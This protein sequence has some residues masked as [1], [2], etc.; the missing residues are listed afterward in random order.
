[1][2]TQ[3]PHCDA[4]FQLSTAQ[5]KAANGDVRCGQCLAV[6]S[7]LD[8]LSDDLP[9]ASG[10]SPTSVADSGHATLW[11]ED[12]L[13]TAP[14]EDDATE[15]TS[16]SRAGTITD[17]EE[18]VAASPAE[19]SSP[20]TDLDTAPDTSSSITSDSP[21]ADIFNEI[22]AEAS[23]HTLPSE[24]ID[25]FEAFL[26]ADSPT[27][28]DDVAASADAD[29]GINSNI[30]ADPHSETTAA[31][32]DFDTDHTDHIDRSTPPTA[33]AFS[34]TALDGY[35]FD[36][37]GI[38]DRETIDT[39]FVAEIVL[40][41]TDELAE[42]DAFLSATETIADDRSAEP[43]TAFEHD[44]AADL[45]SDSQPI[46]IE[47]ADLAPI[48]AAANHD[49]PVP[50]TAAPLDTDAI[51]ATID[52]PI[53]QAATE[54]AEVDDFAEL[55][56][57]A[58]E[59]EAV[60]GPRPSAAAHTDATPQPDSQQTLNVPQLILDDLHAARAEQL[61]P[62]PIPW[63]IGS[64]LL[65][66]TLVLQVAYFSRDE[67]ARDASLRP[68]LIQLCQLAGC[69]LNQ[70]YDI[71]QIEIIGREVRSH[72][73]ARK[74]LIASTSLINHASFVQPYP[75]VTVVFSDINGK[76]MALRRFTPREYLSNN[77]DLAAGMPPDMPVRIELELVDPG[78]AA[79][80]YEFSAEL[81]PR[82]TRPLT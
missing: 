71:A 60:V 61:R 74:A 29:T 41:A 14:I 20:D 44:G 77:A 1:M 31:S 9:S 48:D 10:T 43:L 57:A 65:M 64:L 3:C 51:D 22:I 80:N 45:D 25:R 63:V 79:V 58:A 2:Y 68:W 76:P 7:A 73:T 62:S 5:L 75:L 59:V 52:T 46:I 18:G 26:A 17:S 34:D 81:D 4:I 37:P 28:F 78:K 24:E 35:H 82:N 49:I 56:A 32:S 47:A 53:D 72:P 70:P 55:A 11:E 54:A 30:N 69:T 21:D 27:T 16:D 12:G 8:H 42:L 23:Q 15:T 67:L 13:A 50:D 40:D 66:L 36:A 39:E 33:D 19:S 6:F 38:D